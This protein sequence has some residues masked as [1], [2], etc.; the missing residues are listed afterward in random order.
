MISVYNILYKFPRV[1]KQLRIRFDK[2]VLWRNK[3]SHR[4][5]KKSHTKRENLT[6]KYKISQQKKENKLKTIVINQAICTV[7]LVRK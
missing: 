5:N 7:I 2:I 6:R 1:P 3:K 4:K